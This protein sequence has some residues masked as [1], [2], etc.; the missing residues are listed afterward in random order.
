MRGDAALLVVEQTSAHVNT[1]MYPYVFI[2][3][4]DLCSSPPRNSRRRRPH[5]IGRKR[6]SRKHK[7]PNYTCIVSM[8]CMDVQGHRGGCGRFVC[9]VRERSSP[10][11]SRSFPISINS[12]DPLA[13]HHLFVCISHCTSAVSGPSIGWGSGLAG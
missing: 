9:G 5:R 7:V 10:E 1:Y 13:S 11:R 8:K 4:D 12:G 6:S 2:S 3:L